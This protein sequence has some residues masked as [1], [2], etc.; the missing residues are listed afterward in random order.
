MVVIKIASI[1]LALPFLS[2]ASPHNPLTA[3]NVIKRVD[4]P[5]QKGGWPPV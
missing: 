4:P 3:D 5:S 2:I 1:L